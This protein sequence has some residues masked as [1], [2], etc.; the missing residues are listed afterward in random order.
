M[1]FVTAKFLLVE[2]YTSDLLI[3]FSSSLIKE[4]MIKNMQVLMIF[5]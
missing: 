4:Q 1:E 5:L 3:D 2:G